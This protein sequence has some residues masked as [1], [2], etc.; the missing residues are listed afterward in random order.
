MVNKGENP[1][2]MHNNCPAAHT[3]WKISCLIKDIMIISSGLMISSLGTAVFYAAGLGSS[4]MATFSDGL[5]LMLNASYGTANMIANLVLLAVLIIIARG[6]VKVGTLLCVFTIG[7]WIN[8]FTILL[9][10]LNINTWHIALRIACTVLGTGLMGL[11]LGLYVAVDRGFGALEGLVKYAC[12]KKGMS[13]S[14][15]KVIQDVMLVGGGIALGATW[16][17]GTLVAI[18]FTGPA[19]QWS[20]QCFSKRLT[21]KR[22]TT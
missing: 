13:Y 15:A 9:S 6:Y 22:E 10:A 21:P 3:G 17:I 18:V 8:L 20:I 11:G 7:P 16:G 1:T 14:L 12:A 2:K 5:H 4:P 19:I